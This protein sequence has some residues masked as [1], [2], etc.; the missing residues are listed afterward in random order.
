M[1]F[2]AR[3]SRSPGGKQQSW[4]L[5]PGLVATVSALGNVPPALLLAHTPP[6]TWHRSSAGWLLGLAGR[7]PEVH[8]LMKGA[9]HTAGTWTRSLAWLQTCRQRGRAQ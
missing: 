1:Y 6:S 9:E 3:S 7:S 8:A 5:N 2:R 4:D